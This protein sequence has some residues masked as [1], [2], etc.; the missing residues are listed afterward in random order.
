MMNIKFESDFR[1]S[2]I[3]AVKKKDYKVIYDETWDLFEVY[4]PKQIYVMYFTGDRKVSFRETENKKIPFEFSY[5]KGI[6]PE[7]IA[8][9]IKNHSE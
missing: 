9:S 6:S 1:N 4:T 2:V 8:Q 3:S 7:E 5:Y